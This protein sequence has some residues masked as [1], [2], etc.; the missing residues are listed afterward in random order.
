V[1]VELVFRWRVSCRTEVPGS[2]RAPYTAASTGFGGIQA[3]DISTDDDD[4]SSCV[5]AAGTSVDNLIA[6]A[7]ML[8]DMR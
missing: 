1:T 2:I 6:H 5:M 3:S 7:A 8:L 4:G